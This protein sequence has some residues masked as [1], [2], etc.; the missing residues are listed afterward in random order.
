MCNLRV[1]QDCST[2]EISSND[3]E[4][5]DTQAQNLFN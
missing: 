3:S 2:F 4:S 5:D 1:P